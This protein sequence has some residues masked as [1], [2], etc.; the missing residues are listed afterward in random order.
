VSSKW[1]FDPI[2]YGSDSDKTKIGFREFLITRGHS[3]I[4]FEAAKEIFHHM[5]PFIQ[6]LVIIIGVLPKMVDVLRW[7]CG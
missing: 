1:L 4:Y 2:Q 6:F 3:T 7:E 5:T